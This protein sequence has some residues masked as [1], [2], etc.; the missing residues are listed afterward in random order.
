MILRLRLNSLCSALK[1]KDSKRAEITRLN[2]Q[3]EN[4]DHDLHSLIHD[5]THR[6]NIVTEKSISNLQF[7]L[8]SAAQIIVLNKNRVN[9]CNDACKTLQDQKEKIEGQKTALVRTE[10]GNCS[11]IY[12]DII[13]LI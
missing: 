12:F 8:R 10:V 9:M 11:N 1:K 3:I 6:Q 13:K 7:E 4:N 2:H 5:A